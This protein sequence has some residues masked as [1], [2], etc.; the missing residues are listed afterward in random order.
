VDIFKKHHRG[1]TMKVSRALIFIDFAF[2]FALKLKLGAAQPDVSPRPAL[3]EIFVY[4]GV[5][6]AAGSQGLL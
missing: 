5:I 2:G 6:H 1:A 4:C 3:L